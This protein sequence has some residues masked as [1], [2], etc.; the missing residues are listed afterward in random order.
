M[1]DKWRVMSNVKEF[2]I[3]SHHSQPPI[4]VA[5]VLAGTISLT[6]LDLRLERSDL[7]L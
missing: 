6:S 5:F 1:Y 2:V 7:S 3:T 4:V